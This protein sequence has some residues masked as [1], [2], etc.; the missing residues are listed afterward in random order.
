MPCESQRALRLKAFFCWHGQ[1]SRGVGSRDHLLS[2]LLKVH[3]PPFPDTLSLICAPSVLSP[4]QQQLASALFCICLIHL[5]L[6]IQA[7]PLFPL[8]SF[9]RFQRGEEVVTI[10]F[11]N[12]S[13]KKK[14]LSSVLTFTMSLLV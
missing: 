6:A 1:L 9:L 4:K 13:K 7:F 8:F 14:D 5:S 3:V 11:I 12:A 2:S 10:A